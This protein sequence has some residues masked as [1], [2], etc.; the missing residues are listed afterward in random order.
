MCIRLPVEGKGVTLDAF[1][2]C[3]LLS[4]EAGPLAEAKSLR[5]A[6]LVISKLWE[7]SV[8]FPHQVRVINEHYHTYFSHGCSRSELSS[9]RLHGRHFIQSSKSIFKSSTLK[10]CATPKLVK[11][12]FSP[13][14]LYHTHILFLKKKKVLLILDSTWK[15]G[16]E[17]ARFISFL[18]KSKPCS[19][20]LDTRVKRAAAAFPQTPEHPHLAAGGLE[21]RVQ[22]SQPVK[23][24]HTLQ[25]VFGSD[26]QSKC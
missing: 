15:Q 14:Y 26:S 12:L 22:K 25:A 24:C 3:S 1:Y 5:L 16:S 4:F 7:T 6:K 2:F 13:K 21:V 9:S 17:K 11:S 18:Q 10:C 19:N 20:F 23:V 8:C